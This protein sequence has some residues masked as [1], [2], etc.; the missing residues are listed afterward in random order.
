MKAIRNR[1][2]VSY[3]GDDKATIHITLDGETYEYVVSKMLGEQIEQTLH[4]MQK[5]NAA[6]YRAV[7]RKER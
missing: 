5:Q 2:A 1:L 3:P 4:R 7:K 6:I